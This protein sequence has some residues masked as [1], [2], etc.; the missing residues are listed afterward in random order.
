MNIGTIRKNDDGVYVGKIET[1]T[2]D[3]TVALRPLASTN[4]RAPKFEVMALNK[5]ARR[6]VQVGAL[7]ELSSNSTGETF[8]QGRVD[9]PSLPNPL[10][11]SLFRQQDDSMNVVW[12][13]P[14]RQTGTAAFKPQASDEL[15]PLP[16]SEGGDATGSTGD[17]LGES[18]AP[19]GELQPA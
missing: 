19:A 16:G 10:P 15:P 4:E 13:R 11:I 17:G 8:L 7:F 9:D 3:M 18:T 14:Q 12:R 2:V 5:A 6:W 1:L